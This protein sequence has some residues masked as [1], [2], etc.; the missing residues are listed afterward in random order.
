M[1]DLALNDSHDIYLDPATNDIAMVTGRDQVRQSL[2][3]GLKLFLGEWFDNP[4]AGLPY[5]QEIL[6]KT[7][8]YDG[9]GTQRP[10][11]RTIEAIFRKYILARPGVDSILEFEMSI[12]A[13]TR[14][15]AIDFIVMSNEG[16]VAVSAVFP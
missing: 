10:S 5:W 3:I 12:T 14:H 16:D 13:T 11:S 9:S 4:D 1:L 15:A 6:D 7:P 8:S 2:E